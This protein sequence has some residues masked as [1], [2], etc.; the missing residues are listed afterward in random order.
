[1]S[2]LVIFLFA[3]TSNSHFN[4]ILN[5]YFIFEIFSVGFL[6]LNIVVYYAYV[7]FSKLFLDAEV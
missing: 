3:V 5:R 7:F 4:L 1:M 6:L 2:A